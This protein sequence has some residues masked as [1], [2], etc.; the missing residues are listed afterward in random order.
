MRLH[1][2]STGSGQ[3]WLLLLPLACTDKAAETGSNCVQADLIAQCPPGSNPV[4]GAEASQSCG[5]KLEGDLLE[6][7][8]SVSAQCNG[9]GECRV[10]CQFLV[11]C[12]CGVDR[13]DRQ[14]IVCSE[15][16]SQ[17]CGDGRC[18]GTER[19]SCAPGVTGCQPCAE[20]CGG[21]TCGDG[22]CTGSESP[23]TCPV[24]CARTCNPGDAPRCAGNQLI[25]CNANGTTTEA[26]CGANVCGPTGC[27]PPNICGNRVCES[28][29]TTANCAV[30]CSTTCAPSSTRCEA[31]VLVTCS[32][33]GQ[34]ETRSDCA[35][36]SRICQ[37]GACVSANVCS[38]GL[39]EAGEN[40]V[41]CPSDCAVVC[42]NRRCE[43]GELVS[44]PGDCT[45]C[46]NDS[47]ELDEQTTCPQDCGVCNPSARICLGAILQVCNAN[48]TASNDIDC[49]LHAQ[50]CGRGSCVPSDICGNGVCEVSDGTS[51]GVDCAEVCGNGTCGSG[52]TFVSCSLDCERVCG[53]GICDSGETPALCPTD[54][55]A[56][57]GNGNCDTFERDVS[58]S[59]CTEDCGFCGDAVCQDGFETPSDRS[60][61]GLTPCPAD[62]VT[63]ECSA[64]ADCSDRIECTTDTCDRSGACV[65]VA[66]DAR[67]GSGKCLGR[68]S[69]NPDGTGCC[70]DADSDGFASATCG[71]TDCNDNDLSTRPGAIEVCGGPDKNCNG[72]NR[73]ALRP[74]T[75]LTT[76]LDGKDGFTLVPVGDGSY[77]AAWIDRP[78]GLPRLVATVI[79]PNRTLTTPVVLDDQVDTAPA[80]EHVAGV[81]STG[82]GHCAFAWVSASGRASM[83]WVNPATG[84]A[85]RG[86]PLAL[87][88]IG[89]LTHAY[90]NT[91]VV[92]AYGNGTHLLS[93]AIGTSYVSVADTEEITVGDQDTW[94]TFATIPVGTGFV[95]LCQQG[96]DGG[97]LVLARIRSVST[98]GRVLASSWL[99]AGQ[100]MEL[101]TPVFWDGAAAFVTMSYGTAIRMERFTVAGAAA[102]D[103]SF[104]SAAPNVQ[105]A[106]LLPDPLFPAQSK[107]G[108]LHAD[109][110]GLWFT[111]RGLD[112]SRSLDSGQIAAATQPRRARLFYDGTSFTAIW[113]SKVSGID[114][115]FTTTVGCQ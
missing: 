87:A 17:S 97:G 67:C 30:D 18:E 11:P 109:S 50:I 44:C 19:A 92:M 15:C 38:N 14:A 101:G 59:Y 33:D 26:D 56:T 63:L 88:S 114:Q 4:L 61:G 40:E 106:V 60:I 71:G 23:D 81:F 6:Q 55:R 27:V 12:T 45:V 110:S 5:G 3:A 111:I 94:R 105:D 107:V 75:Q 39:C 46:G 9:S 13:I 10:L 80:G 104:M 29:E 78:L 64:P 66:D 43:T 115:I 68:L 91:K 34:T 65:Y 51:C 57:C 108:I 76:D 113:I 25:L 53:D 84:A 54:C 99:S 82:R 24:D 32:A 83:T 49:A 93:F 22:D 8:G 62:C 100:T 95:S 89:F 98:A 2:S 102:L 1:P 69:S 77:C 70:A 103:A 58:G 112:G 73:P 48:G 36:A 21:A 72:E 42:G 41:T 35:L 47:C 7:S 74:A 79:R 31:D 96:G 52:E 28:G 86:A 90:D 37:N 20:D 85:T 16:S